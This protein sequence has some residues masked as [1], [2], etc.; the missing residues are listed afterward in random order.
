MENGIVPDAQCLNILYDAA[1]AAFSEN[2]MQPVK[3]FARELL[4]ELREPGLTEICAYLEKVRDDINKLVYNNYEKYEKHEIS[5]DEIKS[6][7]RQKY[8]WMDESNLSRGLSQ[9][10]YYAWR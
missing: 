6:I 4:P 2:F 3:E 1:L 8:P 10:M 9:G 5:Q 7:I